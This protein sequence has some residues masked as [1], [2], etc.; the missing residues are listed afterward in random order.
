MW[1]SFHFLVSSSTAICICTEQTF[2]EASTTPQQF[3][4]AF[5]TALRAY[6][7]STLERTVNEKIRALPWK[8][9]KDRLSFENSQL[10]ESVIEIIMSHPLRL[11]ASA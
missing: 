11:N 8:R 6:L 2:S 4:D 5:S 7:G 10:H 3:C 9:Y 1:R